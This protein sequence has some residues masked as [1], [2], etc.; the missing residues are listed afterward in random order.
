MVKLHVLVIRL[1]L[2]QA[3][4]DSAYE[5]SLTTDQPVQ[6]SEVPSQAAQVPGQAAQVDD[7]GLVFLFGFPP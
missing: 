1:D 7:Q 4:P 2:L 5:P 6:A 3:I